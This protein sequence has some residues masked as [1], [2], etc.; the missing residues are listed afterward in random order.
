MPLNKVGTRADV[1]FQLTPRVVEGGSQAE[2][3]GGVQIG[4]DAIYLTHG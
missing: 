3:F 1:A 4:G 2:R